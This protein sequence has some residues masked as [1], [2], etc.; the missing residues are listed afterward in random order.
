MD[1]KDRRVVA[2]ETLPVRQ[3][4]GMKKAPRDEV[5]EER[6]S[7][8]TCSAVANDNLGAASM[9]KWRRSKKKPLIDTTE[10][11]VHFLTLYLIL[12]K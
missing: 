11:S 9:D 3:V 5:S 7:L 4:Q 2:W 10:T 12:L 8:T 6:F 1:Y